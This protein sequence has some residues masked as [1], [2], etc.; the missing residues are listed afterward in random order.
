LGGSEAQHTESFWFFFATAPAMFLPWTFLIP[1]A[2]LGLGSGQ[3]P[4]GARQ[5]IRFALAWFWLP[6]LFFS[7]SSGKLLTY[8]L[9]C[10]PPFA[11]LASLGLLATLRAGRRQLFQV[12]AGAAALIFGGLAVAFGLLQVVG[13][14]S[15]TPPYSRAGQGLL[16]L[17]ILTIMALLPLAAYRAQAWG[18]KL[19][20][21]G[22]S[23]TLFLGATPFIIPDQL[24]EKKMPGALLLRQQAALPAE[25]I[26]LS[27]EDTLRAVCWYWQRADVWLVNGA[28]ELSYG[29]DYPDGK[30]RLLNLPAAKAKIS[31]HP[32]RIVLVARGR[33]YRQWAAQLPPPQSV[34]DSGREGYV[35]VRY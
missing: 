19:I 25:T 29:L 4:P 21:F 8:I 3:Q 14:G 9:P 15:I 34:D 24:L 35:V 31:A 2:A 13:L 33:N 30:G 5:L 22:L 12:G 7:L 26:V 20:L 18:H 23:M 16:A 11:I 17:A 28:G 27:D 1:A 6:S 32:G 10:F